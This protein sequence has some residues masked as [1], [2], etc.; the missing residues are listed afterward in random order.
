MYHFILAF[1]VLPANNVLTLISTL[2]WGPKSYEVAW[3]SMQYAYVRF[4]KCFILFF[5]PEKNSSEFDGM[6]EFN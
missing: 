2:Q 3:F 6:G 1:A 5:N 4:Q